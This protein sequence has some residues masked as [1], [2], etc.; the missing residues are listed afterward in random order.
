M[1]G[2]GSPRIIRSKL[3]PPEPSDHVVA[4]PRIEQRLRDLLERHAVVVVSATAGSGKTTAVARALA[5]DDRLAWLTLDDGDVAPGRLLTYL[6][7]AV[8]ARVPG[9]DG[10]ATAALAARASH[11]EAAGLLADSADGHPLVLV[12]DEVERLIDATGAMSV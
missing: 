10:V 4:R 8:A 6:E 3:R 7:A 5:G 9:A 12:I 11:A 1:N 2:Q